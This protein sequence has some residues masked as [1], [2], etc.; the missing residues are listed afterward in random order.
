MRTPVSVMSALSFP[1]AEVGEPLHD[2]HP[3]PLVPVLGRPARL[4]QDLLVDRVVNWVEHGELHR[5]AVVG[6]G[7]LDRTRPSLQRVQ[8]V[9][10]N[11]V[12]ESF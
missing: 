8:P 5:V 12:A 1:R 3:E 9:I 7:D 6:K 2:G 11:V 4:E 10:L